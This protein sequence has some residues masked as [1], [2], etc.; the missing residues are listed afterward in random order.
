MA[1]QR[2]TEDEEPQRPNEDEERIRGVGDQEDE[3][4][5]EE[6]LDEEEGDVDEE[7]VL[8]GAWNGIIA[9]TCRRRLADRR[10]RRSAGRPTH[11]QPRGTAPAPS[12]S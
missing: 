12:E 9:G 10:A 5:D 1:D 7:Y 6:D 8:A 4:L 2:N 3:E 11:L